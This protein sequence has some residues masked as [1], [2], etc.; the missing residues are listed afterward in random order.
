MGY[1]VVNV[2]L[3]TGF[4]PN[5]SVFPMALPPTIVPCSF[6]Y[7]CITGRVLRDLFTEVLNETLA[8]TPPIHMKLKGVVLIYAAPWFNFYP[9]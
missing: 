8:N 6:W 5:I 9:H 3:G 1:V 7:T 4:S 2:T